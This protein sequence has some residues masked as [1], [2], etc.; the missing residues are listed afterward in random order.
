MWQSL[1]TDW[2][3]TCLNLLALASVGLVMKAIACASALRAKGCPLFGKQQAEPFQGPLCSSSRLSPLF[4]ALPV[5]APSSLERSQPLRCFP[6]FL[7]HGG[8]CLGALV[9]YYWIY[10]RV[11]D[12]FQLHGLALSYLAAPPV[13]LITEVFLA[14][15][16]ILWLPSGRLLPALHRNPLAARS[17][18]DFWG[19]RWNLWM[20]DWFRQ[21]IF[22]PLR[23]RP[24]LA[25]WLIFFLSGLLHEY[26]LNL[27]LW[28]VVGKKLFG[29]MMLY[30]LLQAAGVWV[31]RR[32]LRT[33]GFVHVLFTWV[34][35]FVPVPLVFHESMLR[36]IHLWPD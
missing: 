35:V 30:F 1:N 28:L 17:V 27:A 16:T 3:M 4:I 26:V 25:V 34:V 2:R 33:T 15:I 21:V 31:E 7:L 8:G 18:A 29:T 23:R 12:A 6:R 11:I 10:W 36:T 5:L 32:F 22:T 13:L 14:M 9:L 19:R 20:S 24:V